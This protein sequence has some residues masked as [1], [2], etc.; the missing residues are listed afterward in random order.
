MIRYSGGRG[1]GRRTAHSAIGDAAGADNQAM[2]RGYQEKIVRRVQ[3]KDLDMVSRNRQVILRLATL[4][5]LALAAGPG[6]AGQPTGRADA[7]TATA[8]TT[9]HNPNTAGLRGIACAPGGV[10]Y[11]VGLTGTILMM[12]GAGSWT[13]RSSPTTKQLSSVACPSATVC[14]AV[15][16]MGTIVAT[17]AA[18]SGA[19][20]ARTSHTTALLTSMACPSVTVCYAVGT[21][22]PLSATMATILT[23]SDGGTTWT[24]RTFTAKSGGP[25][26]LLSIAC[27]SVK[28]CYAVGADNPLTPTK[29]FIVATADGGKTWTQR[30]MAM[31]PNLTGVSCPTQTTCYAVG[32]DKPTSPTK[33]YVVGGAAQAGV[34]TTWKVLQT[35][36]TPKLALALTCPAV[37]ACVAVGSD[38]LVAPTK[39]YVATGADLD[40]AGHWTAQEITPPGPKILFGVACTAKACYAVGNGIMSGPAPRQPARSQKP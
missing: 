29:S 30:S 25:A 21:D 12:S 32:S 19:W 13:T 17:K 35:L 9:Q 8:W 33:S 4:L 7:A 22:N 20:G 39:S 38:S 18:A 14:Y 15:G 26:A 2:T 6:S 37:S 36:T 24:P 40:K 1:P 27:P 10:C 28:T 31:P 16:G 34:I 3:R 11:A 5:T 23:T